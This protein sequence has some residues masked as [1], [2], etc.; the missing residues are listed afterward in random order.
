MCGALIAVLGSACHSDR[1]PPNL[2]LIVVDTLRADRLSSYGYTRP[3]SPAI[4]E[5]ARRGV[6]FRHVASYSTWTLPGVVAVLAG[7][8]PPLVFDAV[9]Y[10]PLTLPTNTHV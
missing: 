1:P 7:D 3:T 8:Y 4:D 5:L 10:T 2:L 9:P 6:L